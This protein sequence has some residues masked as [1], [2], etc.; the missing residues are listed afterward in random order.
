MLTNSQGD[1]GFAE[2]EAEVNLVDLVPI[3][4]WTWELGRGPVDMIGDGMHGV[5]SGRQEGHQ[6]VVRAKSSLWDKL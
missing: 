5:K 6:C 4:G 2:Y 1:L 3:P